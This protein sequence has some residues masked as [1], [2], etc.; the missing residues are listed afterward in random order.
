MSNLLEMPLVLAALAFSAGYL[1][2]KVGALFSR[3]T[4]AGAKSD[5][6]WE[7]QL[8]ALNAELRISNKQLEEAQAEI[9][10][11]TQ[12]R[13]ELQAELEKSSSHLIEANGTLTN[14]R[15]QLQGECEK[16]QALRTELTQR[17]EQGIRAQ[18]QIRDMETELSLA[19][20]SGAAVADE[21]S[22]L[23]DATGELEKE[24]Q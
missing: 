9:A 23:F 14:L 7:R 12:A 1:L 3:K 20:G 21:I 8:R 5:P 2:A 15:E 16:T 11:L 17:A 13:D 19:Q 10:D 4:A 18:L 6:D 22:Q 24:P